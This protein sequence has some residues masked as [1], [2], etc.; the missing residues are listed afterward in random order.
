MKLRSIFIPITICS[1]H[2]PT[3]PLDRCRNAVPN[4]LRYFLGTVRDLGRFEQI[5]AA[6]AQVRMGLQLPNTF[7]AYAEAIAD[8]KTADRTLEL[9]TVLVDT[10]QGWEIQRMWWIPGPPLQ[11][12]SGSQ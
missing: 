10:G 11:N 4:D 1:G 6:R 8:A 2:S 9:H 5:S 7:T 3:L 12:N